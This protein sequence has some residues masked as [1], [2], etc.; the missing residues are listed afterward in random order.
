[1]ALLPDILGRRSI[2][3]STSDHRN[4]TYLI[5]GA[6]GS[7]PAVVT[8]ADLLPEGQAAADAPGRSGREWQMV[9]VS[10]ESL[11]Q[12]S[13]GGSFWVGPALTVGGALWLKMK[14]PIWVQVPAVGSLVSPIG[15]DDTLVAWCG[16]KVNQLPL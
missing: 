12:V 14:P 2:L 8:T 6:L 4:S 15:Q 1:M 11:F 7:L 3:P 9:R 5:F 10:P 13:T 16:D